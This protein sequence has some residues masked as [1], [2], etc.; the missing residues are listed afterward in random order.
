MIRSLAVL[1]VC[2]SMMALE[3]C[4]L[5]VKTEPSEV[6]DILSKITYVQEPRSGLCFAILASLTYNGYRNFSLTNVPCDKV[7]R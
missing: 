2:L 1:F 5:P 3:S 6:T 4:S 7:P